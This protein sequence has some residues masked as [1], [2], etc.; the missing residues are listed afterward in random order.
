MELLSADCFLYYFSI[1]AC[2]NFTY[3]GSTKQSL[4]TLILETPLIELHLVVNSLRLGGLQLLL[5]IK[6]TFKLF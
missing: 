3:M 2:L 1:S 4:N 6:R 5:V